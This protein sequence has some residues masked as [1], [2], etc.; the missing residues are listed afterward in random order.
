MTHE[1]S[2]PRSQRRRSLDGKASERVQI[3]AAFMGLLVE[4]SIKRI[5]IGQIA[6]AGDVSPQQLRAE[7]DSTIAVAAAHVER[8]DRL[9]LA[10]E[11]LGIVARDRGLAMLLSAVLRTWLDGEDPGLT[12]AVSALDRAGAWAAP[13]RRPR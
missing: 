10:T 12:H 9:A 2:S 4:Q 11:N 8:I 3:V 5:D 6:A 13:R 1:S 7:L